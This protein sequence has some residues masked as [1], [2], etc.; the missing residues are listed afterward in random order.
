MKEY[1]YI[2]HKNI[3]ILPYLEPILKVIRLNEHLIIVHYNDF[4]ALLDEDD[5]TMN[6]IDNYKGDFRNC[7]RV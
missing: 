5:N 2:I 4:L 6:I 3:C 1:K 7:Y